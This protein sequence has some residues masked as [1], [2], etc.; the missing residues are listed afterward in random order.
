MANLTRSEALLGRLREGKIARAEFRRQYRQEL[1]Y[2][3]TIDRRNG[4]IKNNGK[5]FTPWH[6][7]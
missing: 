1:K 7:D 3:G 6:S 2:E 5:K 4:A